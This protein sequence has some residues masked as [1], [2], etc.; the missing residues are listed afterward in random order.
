MLQIKSRLSLD[1]QDRIGKISRATNKSDTIDASCVFDLGISDHCPIACISDNVTA[2][3][4]IQ[5]SIVVKRN[6][7]DLN[8]QAF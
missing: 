8:D 3:K 4:R 5:S 2:F 7:R 1:L 6:I